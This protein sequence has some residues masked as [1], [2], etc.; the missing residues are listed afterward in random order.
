MNA[1][2]QSGRRPRQGV[3]CRMIIVVLGGC[4]PG[5]A[6]DKFVDLESV[7]KSAPRLAARSDF[8]PLLPVGAHPAAAFSSAPSPNRWSLLPVAPAATSS[9][10]LDKVE[11]QPRISLSYSPG[12]LAPLGDA[13]TM[14]TSIALLVTSLPIVQTPFVQQVRFPVATLWAGR[15]QFGGFESRSTGE[16]LLWGL[17]GSGTLPAWSISGQAH[18]GLWGPQA[19][20]S[21]G[22]SLSLQLKRDVESSS[23]SRIWRC[24]GWFVGA[25][26]GCRLN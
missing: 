17:P 10:S 15:L 5:L 7:A 18:P 4:L 14:R 9:F 25:G 19:D 2:V 11:P 3:L 24:L 1:G 8:R 21:V 26:L 16:N 6:Q 13:R 23:R 12:L 22:L 20:Q